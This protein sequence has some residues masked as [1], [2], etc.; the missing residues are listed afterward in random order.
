VDYQGDKAHVACLVFDNWEAEK[1]TASYTC[2][3]EN[4]AD[5]EPGNFFKRE[6]PCLVAAIALVKERF[7]TIVIDGYVWLGNEPKK[8]L[9][10]HLYDY[11]EGNYTIIG[12]AKRAFHDSTKHQFEV[13]RGES[14][15]PLFISTAG[16]DAS[17]AVEAISTMHGK[18]RIPTLL[19]KVDS[20][21][22]DW[23]EKPKKKF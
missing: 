21:C 16:I 6:L 17:L 9:G 13:Y 10:A 2:I 22:R 12:V 20:V 15:N 3:C 19:K 8:G 1:E 18:F 14:K 23:K 4:I 11:Y 7:S 5:Y